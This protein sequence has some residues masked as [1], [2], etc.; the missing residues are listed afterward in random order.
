MNPFKRLADY[1]KK[2]GVKLGMTDKKTLRVITDHERVN[3]EPK[4]YA[5]IMEAMRYY[6]GEY[7]K[8][9]YYD[10][11]G[12]RCEREF[13]DLP[14]TVI[15]AEYLADLIINESFDVQVKSANDELNK[16][17]QQI[18]DDNAFKK[19]LGDYLSPMFAT[20]G[21]A[22]RP[23][24]NV[25]SNEMEFSWALSDAFFP[26]RSNSNKISEGV[27]MTTSKRDDKYYT[28]LEF[29]QWKDNETYMIINELYESINPDIIGDPVPL[30][31]MYEQ[32]EPVT[33]IRGL[34]RP[35]FVYLKPSNFNNLA[36]HSPL[37]LGVVD[38]AKKIL[39][40]INNTNNQMQ[41]DMAKAKPRIAISEAMTKAVY[42]ERDGSFLGMKV[43]DSDAFVMMTTDEAIVKD[44][45]LEFEPERYID[46][47]NHDFRLLE[48]KIKLQ[49][50]T[51]SLEY[52]KGIKTA[53]QVVSE[54]SDTFRTRNREI[55]QIETFIKELIV[56]LTELMIALGMYNGDVPT[57][58]E[59]TVDFD[60][61]IFTNKDQ[62]LDFYMK[63][64]MANMVPKSVAIQR[65][66]NQSE[67]EAEEWLRKIA[68]ENKLFNSDYQSVINDISLNGVEE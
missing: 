61:G 19:N 42:D 16:V 29:H 57:F 25:T 41:H 22:V 24:Y 36:P 3:I 44:I 45:S 43:D 20:G 54:D 23:Y 17:L 63:G 56:S 30:G 40:Q 60:D 8:E 39:D 28:L 51:F 50:G 10:M 9:K 12:V 37:G 34:S 31:V 47:I 2:G 14:M 62:E 53:T 21:I 33:L 26:L 49:Q 7:P 55:T 38:N 66:Y 67:E 4:E 1:F 11:N 18:L 15:V 13:Y 32:L 65:A 27:F 46:K 58:E 59:I 52:Q 68:E 64:V 6:R 35:L 5:R 48:R